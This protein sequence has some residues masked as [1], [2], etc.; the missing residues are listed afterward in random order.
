MEFERLQ[1]II[2]GVLG[3]D[4]E[5]I[6]PDKSFEDDLGADS[7]D[8]VEIIMQIEDELDVEISEEEAMNITTVESAFEA[9][10]RALN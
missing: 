8:R 5:S 6:T 9:I 4:E 1:S 7:L 10:K 2:A 3:V